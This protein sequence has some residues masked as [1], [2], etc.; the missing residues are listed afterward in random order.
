[1][2]IL[3]VYLASQTLLGGDA[4]E[5]T[6][7]YAEVQRLVRSHPERLD[8]VIFRPGERK[9]VVDLD[10]GTKVSARYPITQSQ[11]ELERLIVRVRR[12]LEE[13][14]LVRVMD[15]S[16]PRSFPSSCSSA[17]GSSWSTADETGPRTRTS[18]LT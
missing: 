13:Q 3:L 15:D 7:T 5:K 2:I 14:R 16:S 1:V 18:H 17:S 11:V 8:K 4:K 12:R 6:L 10:N 9:V